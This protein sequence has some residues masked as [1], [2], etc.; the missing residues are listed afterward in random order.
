MSA[1]ILLM[2]P[3]CGGGRICVRSSAAKL[4]PLVLSFVMTLHG[5]VGL[6]APRAATPLACLTYRPDTTRIT[7]R[8]TRRSFFGA[9][10]FG[11]DPQHDSREIGFYLALN[12]PICTTRGN[13]NEAVTNVRLVQL[14]LDSA[15]YARLRPD[16]GKTVTLRGTLFQAFTAHHHAPLVLD[17]V[18]PK[19]ISQAIPD[20]LRGALGGSVA[21]I[22]GML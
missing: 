8:L 21:S 17:V 10:G 20:A 11:E 6:T 18:K 13:D 2:E 3:A 16:V 12:A 22:R 7:G 9:P 15:D 5:E 19:K 14:V 1:R 4:L